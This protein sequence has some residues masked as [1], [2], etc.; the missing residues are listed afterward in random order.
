MATEQGFSGW[1]DLLHS[2]SNLLEQSGRSAQFPPLQVPPYSIFLFFFFFSRENVGKFKE[3]NVIYSRVELC[4]EVLLAE[5]NE[6]TRNLLL[7]EN[8]RNALF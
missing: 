2:S 3:E 7:A 8:S 4:L 6:G 5:K 1:T